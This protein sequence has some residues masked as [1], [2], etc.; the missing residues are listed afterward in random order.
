M[1]TNVLIPFDLH[2]KRSYLA[3]PPDVAAGSKE[4]LEGVYDPG[5]PYGELT[6]AA[7]IVDVGSNV[8]AF[9][10]WAA[11]RYP[12]SRIFCYE[13]HPDNAAILRRNLEAVFCAAVKL[14]EEAVT[15]MPQTNGKVLLHTA[16]TNCG[17]HSLYDVREQSPTDF[18]EVTASH[19]AKLP[20]AEFIKIDA[21]G[22]ELEILQHYSGVLRAGKTRIVALE[23]HRFSDKWDIVHL[24]YGYGFKCIKE[25]RGVGVQSRP[26]RGNLVFHRAR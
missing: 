5:A 9:A 23:Y 10:W 24:L 15:T 4:V 19:P 1:K 26:D 18:T 2:G 14:R 12:G 13:P 8:G 21:E 22:V 16:V 3:S 7:A 20:N 17:A 11:N 6:S 25:V